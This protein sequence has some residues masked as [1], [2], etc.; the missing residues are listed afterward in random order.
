M[1]DTQREPL[2][3]K[4]ADEYEALR[5]ARS[6]SGQSALATLEQARANG[7]AYD[8]SGQAPAPKYPGLREFGEWPLAD[9]RASIDWTPFFRAWEL[10]GNYPAILEDP[11]V[12][13]SATS[14]FND[15]QAMLDQ[16]IAERWVTA[17]AKVAC[18]AAGARAMTCACSPAT[19]GR[20]CPSCA[21]R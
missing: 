12:G 8:A 7:F 21:S 11:V 2:L 14:L 6:R 9:L 13:E 17:S 5:K 10:A 1:S 16:I 4:T 19:T 20:A 15:A 18:G 3:D